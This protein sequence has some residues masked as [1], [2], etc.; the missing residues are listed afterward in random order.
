[1]SQLMFWFGSNYVVAAVVY[2]FWDSLPH[3]LQNLPE[4]LNVLLSLYGSVSEGFMADGRG[5]IEQMPRDW[6]AG[7]GDAAAA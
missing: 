4:Q 2:A 6:S 7:D 3:V 1:M 5:D